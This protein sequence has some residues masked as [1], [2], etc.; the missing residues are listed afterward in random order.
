MNPHSI[1]PSCGGLM[2]SR[3]RVRPDYGYDWFIECVDC[4]YQEDI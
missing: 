1:C 4:G 2:Q 3:K